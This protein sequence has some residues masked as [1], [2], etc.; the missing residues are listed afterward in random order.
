[1]FFR[2]LFYALSAMALAACGT[3]QVGIEPST[4]T[5]IHIP[6][7]VTQSSVAP[8]PTPLSTAVPP[9]VRINFPTGS[10]T[11]TF[12]TRLNQGVP[13]RYVLQ[14]L[15]SQ[16]MMI[17]T[18]GNATIEV[19]DAQNQLLTPTSAEANLWQGTIPETGDY[20]I[21]LDGDGLITVTINI[22]PLG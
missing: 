1:M 16:K 3:L 12:T 13:E 20:M 5:T 15:A 4:P 9:P 22:P 7:T 17:S 18:S 2:R 21:V 19:L 6:S 10:T 8:A 11:F 14:I